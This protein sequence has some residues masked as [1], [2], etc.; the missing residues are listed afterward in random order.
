MKDGLDRQ[1]DNMR[2]TKRDP[3]DRRQLLFHCIDE[4]DDV[5]S[6]CLGCRTSDIHRVQILCLKT[7]EYPLHRLRKLYITYPLLHS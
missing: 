1:R 4:V 5:T 2:T 6:A 3:G 7:Q